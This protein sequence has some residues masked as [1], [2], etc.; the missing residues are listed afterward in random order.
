MHSGEA[1]SGPM[2]AATDHSALPCGPDRNS[3]RIGRPNEDQ[4][5]GRQQVFEQ[6]F[7]T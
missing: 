7:G 2:S 1:P 3:G 5:C 6:I 4:L